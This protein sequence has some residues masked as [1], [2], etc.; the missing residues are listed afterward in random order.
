MFPN[1]K[2][3]FSSEEIDEIRSNYGLPPMPTKTTTS[4]TTKPSKP[5]TTTSDPY[6]RY[7][8]FGNTFGR[9]WLLKNT[10]IARN[11]YYEN[12]PP[13]GPGPLTKALFSRGAL[14]GYE[15]GSEV[16]ERIRWDKNDD[17][18]WRATTKA[19]Y[20][21]NEVPGENKVLPASAVIGKF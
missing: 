6:E 8:N 11:N 3:H 7:H 15:D 18:E 19:P 14:W 13:I 2:S 21:E 17:K 10:Y 4:R 9:N 20:F 5:T 16:D 12:E 1:Q